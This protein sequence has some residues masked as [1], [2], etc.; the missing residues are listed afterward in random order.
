MIILLPVLAYLFGSISSAVVVSK[1][2]GL[3]DPRTAG[4]NNPGATNVLRLG[5]KKAAVITLIGDVLKGLI[6]ML[7]ARMLSDSSLTLA[8]VGLAAFLG[9]LYPVFFGFK[10]GKGVATA[11]G[12]FI[13]LSSFLVLILLAVWLVIAVTTRYSSLAAL[14]AAAAAPFLVLA[15]LPGLPLF[16]MALI[17]AVML[18]WRHREN[19]SRLLSGNE[20]RINLKSRS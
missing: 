1:L 6:P 4:S 3:P 11:A 12:V 10:G 16:L 18:F 8:L 9:H 2:M 5:G 17:I 7:I 15:V 19:I 14:V 20:S 13:G